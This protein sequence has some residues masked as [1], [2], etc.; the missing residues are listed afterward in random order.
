MLNTAG[1]TKLNWGSKVVQPSSRSPIYRTQKTQ[2]KL[3]CKLR[4]TKR[5]KRFKQV[6]IFITKMQM[7][8]RI[9]LSLKIS[10]FSSSYNSS[11]K[12]NM[13]KLPLKKPSNPTKI[14][15]PPNP[16]LPRNKHLKSKMLLQN[17]MNQH[18][19][20]LL[21]VS[22]VFMISTGSR[23]TCN[24]YINNNT[25]RIHTPTHIRVTT[26]NKPTTR[27]RLEQLMV[28]CSL[29][30][31]IILCNRVTKSRLPSLQLTRITTS[32]SL[33]LIFLHRLRVNNH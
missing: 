30:L 1:K 5:L 15:S 32:K 27:H 18:Q 11:S 4:M 20:N 16:S 8:T 28:S 10:S 13:L 24:K 25:D 29:Y 22:L 31:T 7:K 19:S 14:L 23:C 12:S 2:Q 3:K 9:V 33:Y 17:T 6:S 21:R 26:H